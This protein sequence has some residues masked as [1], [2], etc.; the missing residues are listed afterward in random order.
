QV[1]GYLDHAHKQSERVGVLAHYSE[2]HDN[3]RLAKKGRA[4]SLLRNRLCALASVNGAFGFTCGVEWLATDRILVHGC[5]GL[6]WH[7][8][9]NI[10]PELARLNGLVSHHPCFFDRDARTIE[11]DGFPR[12]RIATRFSGRPGRRAG[13]GEH[14][15]RK[16]PG[17]DAWFGPQ[18]G[19]ASARADPSGHGGETAPCADFARGV[20]RTTDAKDQTDERRQTDVRAAAGRLLLPG[21]NGTT[22]WVER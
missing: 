15:Y 12:I 3:D 5:T 18:G 8:K 1:A 10:I 13:I 11:S 17:A 14:G 16:E 4:W 22:A 6:A 9:E 2:T 21:T 7:S 20:A 19:L